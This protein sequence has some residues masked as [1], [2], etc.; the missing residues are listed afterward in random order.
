[1]DAQQQPEKPS[2]LYG[3]EAWGHDLVTVTDTGDVALRDPLDPSIP[4]VSLPAIIKDLNERGITSPIQLRV[5]SFLDM[6]I[7]RL[8]KAFADAIRE[9]GYQGVY[10]GVFPI[11]VNQ[12][13]EVVSRLVEVGRPYHYGLEAGS[14]PELI[15]ALAQEMAKESLIICNGVKDDEFIRL[16]ILSRKLGFN[17]VIVLESLKEFEIVHRVARELDARPL[18]GVRIKLTQTVTGKWE[19]SSGDRSTFGLGT[20]QVVRLVD[21]LEETGFLDCLVLQHSHLGSQVPNIIDIRRT[22][23]ESARFYTELKALGVPLKYLDLGGGLGVDYTGEKR[24]TDNSMNY[25][26]EEYC[27][28]ILESVRYAM[29]EAGLEH[30][31]LV[32]ESGRF[33][34]ALSSMLI[35]NVLDAT[36]YDTPVRPE[37][38]AGDHHFVKD[39]LAVEGYV[40]P[41]RLQ[42]SLNDALYYRDE[43]R[44]L[45]RRGQVDIRQ[46]ARAEQGFLYIRSL[47]NTQARTGDHSDEVDEALEGVVDY[48]HGNFSLFQ[49]LPDVWAID[50]V[51]PV[52]PLQ[53]LNEVPNRRVVF[54][55]ITCDS[56][57]KISHF[58]LR[59]GIANSLPVHDLTEEDEYY[60]GVFF[61]GAYQETLGDLHNLFGDA[62]V[63]TI[64]L[65]RN[66]G[67]EIEHETE[68]D[69]IAQVLS[70]VEYDPQDCLVAFRRTVERAVKAGQ[71]N[72]AQRRILMDAYKDSLAGYT[73][74][75]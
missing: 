72:A 58:V 35:F 49:S 53:R 61:V 69:T 50:Q 52:I 27:T 26:V 10:R 19:A 36:L 17:T 12:Q 13:A 30:P 41:A 38:V 75:E 3:I 59:D 22:V 24:S 46:M 67:F 57:G 29:D 33:V 64:S 74:F 45:F 62:N 68:G 7:H 20:E 42:E 40:G 48:Y 1:M 37:T 11:K 4:P 44:A 66:G 21:R 15:V 70:Y 54:T 71:V 16:A 28:N 55:D 65:N 43:M 31:T 5:Q 32:T 51:H 9:T 8:N 34:V 25:T 23:A 56:D 18:L 63:V 73:Y 47:I 14:K 60:I 6:G 2:D 39:L